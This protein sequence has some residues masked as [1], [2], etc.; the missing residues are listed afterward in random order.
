MSTATQNLVSNIYNHTIEAA[1]AATGVLFAAKAAP[2]I[3]FKPAK[4][5]YVLVIK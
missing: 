4:P 2:R 5:Y 1:L 3:R